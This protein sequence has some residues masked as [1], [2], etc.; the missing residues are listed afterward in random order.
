MHRL[1]PETEAQSALLSIVKQNPHKFSRQFRDNSRKAVQVQA[2]DLYDKGMTFED[3]CRQLAL[4]EADLKDLLYITG[5]TTKTGTR[6][7]TSLRFLVSVNNI[8]QLPYI[9]IGD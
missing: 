4:D 9:N 3:L 8:K 2:I 1:P 6:T 5:R 7:K